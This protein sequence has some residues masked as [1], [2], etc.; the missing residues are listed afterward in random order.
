MSD[1][2]RCAASIT[3]VPSD[4]PLMMRLRLGKFWAMGGVPSGSLRDQCPES[5]DLPSQLAMAYRIDAVEPG[6]GHR[7]GRTRTRQ[8][9]TMGR[10]VD[11]ERQPT[12]DAEPGLH[13]GAA[14]LVGELHP[15]SAGVAAPHDSQLGIRQHAVIAVDEDDRRR[16][17]DLAQQRGVIGVREQDDM[18]AGLIVP[19]P[20]GI[21]RPPLRGTQIGDGLAV[22]PRCGELI[23][24]RTQHRLR[25]AEAAV[26][27]TKGACRHAWR[28]VQRQPAGSLVT[29]LHGGPPEP[30]LQEGRPQGAALRAFMAGGTCL[31]GWSRRRRDA[32][33]ASPP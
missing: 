24:G 23:W 1:P 27:G 28:P 14:E 10:G 15:G 18:V 31:R 26:Q 8:R 2:L 25:A 22:E 6:A 16:V 11:P 3:S 33:D 32:P 29:A 5:G 7:H 30:R 9:S 13:Q 20:G 12:R 19:A 17:R 21:D 4:R